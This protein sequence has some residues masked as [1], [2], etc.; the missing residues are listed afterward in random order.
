[1][2]V[3]Q[4]GIYYRLTHRVGDQWYGAR[5][6]S[7]AV[8]ARAGVFERAS[9]SMWPVPRPFLMDMQDGVTAWLIERSG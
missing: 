8:S 4:V 6:G 1:M 2:L 7:D 5:L 3:L 9:Y